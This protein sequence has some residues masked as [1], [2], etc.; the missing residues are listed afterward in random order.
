[1]K[2]RLDWYA[3]LS[4][5][6]TVIKYLALTMVV[7]LIVA[8]IYGEDLWVFLVS[9]AVALAV[10]IG[11][12][13][14][15]DDP[16]LGPP[17][18]LLL[19]SVSWIAVAVVAAIP[20]M[21]AGYGTASTLRMPVNA[22]FE[23]TSGITTTGATVLGEIS[24]DRHSHA[25]MMWRQLTQWLGGMGIIVLMI[26]ILPELAVNGAQLMQSEAPGP[27]LQKLTPKI[28]ETPPARCGLSISA[29]L[30]H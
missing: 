29:L 2:W 10:G 20:Y 13:Q 5:V 19:V 21:L 4:L 6:G 11:L 26:A 1:M 25:I 27:E 8:V 16:D 7:P 28:A 9:L 23:A 14:L 18:A 24:L 12:E 22:L 3:S 30:S 15:D 17:E